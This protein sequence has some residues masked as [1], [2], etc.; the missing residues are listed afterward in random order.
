MSL[1]L[2]LQGV[3]NSLLKFFKR[4]ENTFAKVFLCVVT[5]NFPVCFI[6]NETEKPALSTCVI[7]NWDMTVT[8]VMY[9]AVSWTTVLST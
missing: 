5:A 3:K 7:P 2:S 4:Y 8:H 1:I 9:R 6:V